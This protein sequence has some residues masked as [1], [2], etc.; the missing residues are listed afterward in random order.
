MQLNDDGFST[1]VKKAIVHLSCSTFTPECEENL[2][3]NIGMI[4]QG[5]E[6]VGEAKE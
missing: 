3:P 2:K 1:P 4:F 5:L 6:A